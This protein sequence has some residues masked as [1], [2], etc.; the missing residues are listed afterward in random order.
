MH[1]EPR[2]EERHRDVEARADQLNRKRA[3]QPCLVILRVTQAE[4]QNAH[5][6]AHTRNGYLDHVPSVLVGPLGDV[7]AVL[8]QALQISCSL[9]GA[10]VVFVAGKTQFEDA[11]LTLLLA[12]HLEFTL[13][14]KG[15]AIGEHY[16]LHEQHNGSDVLFV[17]SLIL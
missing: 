9:V 4:P 10:R 16:L 8:Q 6:A 12:Q 17:G 7:L 14:A 15:F 1:D 3:V 2:H 5:G 13:L 11:N